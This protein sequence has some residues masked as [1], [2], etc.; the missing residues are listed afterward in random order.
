MI[1]EEPCERLQRR[2]QDV[3]LHT[4]DIRFSG[5][6]GH[7]HGDEQID[8]QTT[9]RMDAIGQFVARFGEK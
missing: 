2:L 8:Q 3:M 1:G 5:L 6:F 9:P 4:L 7:T